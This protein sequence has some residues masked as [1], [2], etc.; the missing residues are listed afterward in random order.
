MADQTTPAYVWHDG[1]L[2]PWAEATVHATWLGPAGVSSVFEG[3][4]GYWNAE[5]KQLYIFQLEAHLARFAQSIRLVRM[6][7]PFTRDELRVAVAPIVVG[8]PNGTRWAAGGAYLQGG[9][10]RPY[11]RMR[12]LQVEAVDDLVVSRYRL[13]RAEDERWLR[14]AIEL[15]GRCS[16]SESAFSVGAVLVGPDGAVLG[17]GWSR[18]TGPTAHAEQ[19]ALA[20]ARA[21]GLVPGDP[22]WVDST[23]YTSLEPCSRRASHPVSC[24]EEILRARI[25]RVVMAWRE[26]DVFVD[27]EGAELLAAAGVDVIEV[28]WLAEAARAAKLHLPG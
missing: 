13:V 1:K 18:Q 27:C 7:L 11:R 15:A 28:P 12:L 3:I 23:M 10:S 17:E 21:A 2:V 5:Q 20:A 19:A 9:S 26:P 22:G 14:R 8:D 25:G 4:R 16:A 24:T 6:S